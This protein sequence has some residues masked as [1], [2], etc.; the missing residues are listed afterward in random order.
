[1]CDPPRVRTAALSLALLLA[2]TPA[3]LTEPAVDSTDASEPAPLAADGDELDDLLEDDLLEAGSTGPSDPIEPWNRGVLFFNR[4]LDTVLF[5]PITKAYAFVMPD[6]GKRAVRR[7]FNN[8]ASPPILVN[9]LLQAEGKRALV[10]GTR[11]VVNTTVG[12]AG[13]FDPAAS[14]GLARHDSDFGQTLYLYG[15]QSGPYLMLPIFGPSTAR[16]SVGFIVDGALRPDLWLLGG[17]QIAVLGVGDGLSMRE[18]HQQDLE[19]LKRASI[20][21]YAALRSVYWMDRRHFLEESQ[22]ARELRAREAAQA[23]GLAATGDRKRVGAGPESLDT[24][25]RSHGVEPASP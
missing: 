21:Y 25:D 8:L 2:S 11:F 23:E 18:M 22:R 5:D 24:A 3:G 15:V 19:E 14:I 9:D 12:I 20:D 1:M 16:D 4:G 13:L 10:T 17:A 6:P 7:F